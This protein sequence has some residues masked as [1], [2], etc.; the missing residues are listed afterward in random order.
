MPEVVIKYKNQKALQ[1]LK[2][3]ARY[4]D[5]VISTP[6][7]VPEKQSIN[8]VT[9]IPANNSLDTSALTKFFTGKNIDAG[10]LRTTAWN[11]R[12]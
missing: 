11:R 7:P 9:I 12:K 1:A 6:P 4:F 2:D 8:G 5:F 3:F 10:D